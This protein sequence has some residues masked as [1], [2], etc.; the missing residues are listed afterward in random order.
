[1]ARRGAPYRLACLV[2]FAAPLPALAGAWPT[3][4]GQTQAI[5]KYEE[6]QATR[7]YDPNGYILPIPRL[8]DESLSVFLEHGLTSRLT[9]QARVGVTRGSDAYVRYSG[10]GPAEIGLRYALYNGELGVLSVYA[11]AIAAGVGRNAGYAAPHAGEGDLELRILGG[12]NAKLW[13]KPLFGSVEVARLL[14]R[15]LPD[16]TRV[17][18]TLGFTLSPK[19]LLLVQSYGGQA[20]ARAVTPKW[21]KAEASVVR[22]LGPWSI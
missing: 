8:R 19:W 2:C 18:V 7:A 16:E 6:S 9:F 10:R 20:D 5:V 11:G 21:V 22:H 17:D 1:M 12:R 3:P 13:G 14:R 4:V 15:G